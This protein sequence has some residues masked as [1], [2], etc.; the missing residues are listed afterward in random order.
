MC[1]HLPVASASRR[2]HD[3]MTS[4]LFTDTPR[5]AELAE[6]LERS[7]WTDLLDHFFPACFDPDWGFRQDFSR[8][9][10]AGPSKS[11]G[12]VFQARM[13]WM[14]AT[15]AEAGGTRAD[16]FRG[17]AEHGVRFLL[18]RF[19]DSSSGAMR[20]S[21]DGDGKP[22]GHYAKQFHSYGAS[23]ALYGLAAAARVLG[24]KQALEGA[25][26][27]FSWLE[28]YARDSENGGYFETTDDKNR[29]LLLTPEG[30]PFASE[31]DT[32]GTAYGRKSQNTHLHLLEAFTEFSRVETEPLLRERLREVQG[33]L[34]ERFFHSGSLHLFTTPDWS[35]ISGPVSYGHD[36]E[37]A[38][39][40]MDAAN[41]LDGALDERTLSVARQLIDHSIEHGWDKENGG[42]D[43][44]GDQQGGPVDQ[45]KV[46]WV[47]AE[48]IL[49]LIQGM[50]LPGA[51]ASQYFEWAERTWR[52]TK[53][54]QID[55]EFGGW[56]DSVRPDGRF[57]GL[58]DKGHAWKAAYH[59]GRA[60][61]FG[62]RALRS[63]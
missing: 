58:G 19:Q 37:A 44:L 43:N 57:N 45:T 47:Q 50:E 15:V 5:L 38:H 20:W 34:C 33:I 25:R 3:P 1:Q 49:G 35:P 7:L 30:E 26:K 29:P 41:A 4:H 9:W 12:V 28:S 63:R 53:E 51:P 61:L 24:S 59:D 14:A 36:I 52:W 13:T 10:T 40:L 6:D 18:E 8:D 39:L 48:A 54:N 42:F 2:P 62:A 27:V 60:L 55:P 56:Y 22:E 31:G 23:F 11:R 17:Y 16:E 32:I 46:W 21:I